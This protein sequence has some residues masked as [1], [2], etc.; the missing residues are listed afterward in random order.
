MV[1]YHTWKDHTQSSRKK[2]QKPLADLHI[3]LRRPLINGICQVLRICFYFLCCWWYTFLKQENWAMV[4]K[5][6]SMNYKWTLK[7][8]AW[9]CGTFL[10]ILVL[11]DWQNVLKIINSLWPTGLCLS[12]PPPP[13][14]PGQNGHHFT[15]KIFKG[16]NDKFCSLIRISLKFVP[17][18]PI[19][20]MLALVQVM[21]TSSNGNIFRVTGHLCG[22]FTGPRW[23]PHTKASDAELWC[24]VWSASE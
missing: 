4:S 5:W 19:D 14:P 17:K 20:N 12:H 1:I 22:E 18:H 24:F 21:M 9:Y 10:A 6:I 7:I 16:M 8:T 2:C 23:I 15:D 3:C 11:S 13:P